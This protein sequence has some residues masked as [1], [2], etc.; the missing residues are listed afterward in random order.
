MPWTR[1]RTRRRAEEAEVVPWSLT[2]GPSSF[3]PLSRRARSNWERSGEGNG[4]S[5]PPWLSSPRCATPRGESEGRIKSDRSSFTSRPSLVGRGG[6]DAR[7]PGACRS[8]Q[9]ASSSTLCALC[10][11]RWR[12]AITIRP[13]S[14]TR[15]WTSSCWT[16]APV[17]TRIG[18]R[19]SPRR[20]GYCRRC[21]ASS[22]PPDRPNR[23][24]PKTSRPRWIASPV[25]CTRRSNP[26]WQRTIWIRRSRSAHWRRR[27][28][29]CRCCT[30][31]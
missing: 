14:V 1:R 2:Y 12:A 22:S 9:R 20:C 18:T 3:P 10:G 11:S 21:P 30:G 23:P 28:P 25:H 26:D 16:C 5:R 4:P 19:S 8:D 17:S 7:S 27:R 31:A 6:T 15:S 13:T 29:Y 24:R